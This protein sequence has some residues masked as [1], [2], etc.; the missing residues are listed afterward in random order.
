MVFKNLVWSLVFNALQRLPDGSREKRCC[1]WLS[2]ILQDAVG[3]AMQRDL[4]VFQ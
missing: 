1:K 4:N 2:N 3:S